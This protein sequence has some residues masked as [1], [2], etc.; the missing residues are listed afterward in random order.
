M[1][2]A[3]K[4][5]NYEDFEDKKRFRVEPSRRRTNKRADPEQL[6]IFAERQKRLPALW[7]DMGVV[8]WVKECN[9]PS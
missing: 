5:F 8:E 6:R 9:H 4:N 7:R 1:P 2:D 3:A